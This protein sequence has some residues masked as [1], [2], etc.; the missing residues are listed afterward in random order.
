MRMKAK[1]VIPLTK[2]EFGEILDYL[3]RNA[4]TAEVK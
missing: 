1:G 2:N 4:G 3:R